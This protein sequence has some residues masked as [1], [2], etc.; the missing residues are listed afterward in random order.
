M[1][2]FR[3]SRIFLLTQHVSSSLV[4]LLTTITDY[5]VNYGSVLRQ[6]F[7]RFYSPHQDST[8][9]FASPTYWDSKREYKHHHA[10]SEGCDLLPNSSIITHFSP[11]ET[12]VRPEGLKG[13]G[14]H[15][16]LLGDQQA[17]CGFSRWVQQGRKHT[18]VKYITTTSVGGNIL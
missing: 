11:Q 4:Q 10:D 12:D 1:P 8:L 9:S 7:P 18:K 3:W 5:V 16:V 2:L 15:G 14:C 17:H 6:K 13:S